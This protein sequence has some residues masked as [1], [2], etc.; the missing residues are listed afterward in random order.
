[1]V[2]TKAR[3]YSFPTLRHLSPS[4]C[5]LGWLLFE[6]QVISKLECGLVVTLQWLE[7]NNQGILDGENGVILQV[8]PVAGE[9][10]GCDWH[11][12]VVC[13]LIQVSPIC[14]AIAVG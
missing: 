12:F 9:D 13:G 3:N 5:R 14:Q 11:V 8:R 1:M 4:L 6:L 7:I 10:L 2:Y